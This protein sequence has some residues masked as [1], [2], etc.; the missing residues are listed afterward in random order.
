MHELLLAPGKRAYGVVAYGE[1]PVPESQRCPRVT[2]LG[3]Y[4]PNSR[5]Y[6]RIRLH[7]HSGGAYCQRA[8]VDPLARSAP[9]SLDS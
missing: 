6:T 8:M 2:A 4:A 3:I 7:G 5:Q 1:T 9:A